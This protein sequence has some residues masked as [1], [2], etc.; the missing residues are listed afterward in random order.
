MTVEVRTPRLSA[1]AVQSIEQLVADRVASRI[2]AQDPTLWGSEAEAE[3]RIRL[4]WTDVFDRADAL[5]PEVLA[6]AGGLAELGVDRIVL[7]GMGGSSLAPEVITRAA[8]V[9]LVVLDSTHPAQVRRAVETDLQRAAVVVSSKSGSTIETRS[10]LALFEEAFTA[11]GIDPAERIV[12]VTD[13]D[14]ALEAHA[15]ERGERVFLADP[16]VGGRYSALTAFGLVPSALAGA[17]VAAV[18]AEARTVVGLVASDDIENPALVLAAAYAQGAPEVYT[19]AV[20]ETRHSTA[21]GLADWIEQLIA[22]STGKQGRGLLPIAVGADDPEVGDDYA[23]PAPLTLVGPEGS[24]SA[25][26]DRAIV[27]TA[28]L[29]A[30]LIVWETATAVLGRLLGIDPFDQPDVESAK[31][32]AREVLGTSA[33]SAPAIGTLSSESQVSLLAAP[34]GSVLTNAASLIASLQET[35]GADDYLVIQ[36]YLDRDD[37]AAAPL[38]QLRARLASLLGV[39]VALGFGPR[40][41]HSTG[42]FHKGGPKRGVFLQILDDATPDLAIPG[43]EGGFA[44]LLSAQAQGDRDVLSGAGRPVFALRAADPAV[45]VDELLRAGE[46]EA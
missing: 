20:A 29:G 10:Q 27:V 3:A 45:L 4:G 25:A 12:I 15:R 1:D 11:A 38:A 42:Q 23:G 44:A 18:V 5:I 31:V 41:L 33:G 30:Q 7:C 21:W 35:V 46:I 32:A 26:P 9:D 13:P 16:N 36:A 19:T 40:Y 6:H 43:S 37:R 28:P 17:D 2:F 22:E 24:G 14:S 39:P 34:S 8:G